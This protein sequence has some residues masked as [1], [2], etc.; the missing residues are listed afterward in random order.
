MGLQL[1]S[2]I[3]ANTP[4]S[5]RFTPFFFGG[6]EEIVLNYTQLIKV[7]SIGLPII[8]ATRE[9][10]MQRFNLTLCDILRVTHLNYGFFN[11]VPTKLTK[12]WDRYFKIVEY[13]K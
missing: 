10:R 5:E 2:S 1:V 13:V 11:N 8:N 12:I 6:G 7:I 3:Q 4:F 9:L